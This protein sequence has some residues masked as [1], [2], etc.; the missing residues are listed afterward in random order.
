LIFLLS[1]IYDSFSSVCGRG[2]LGQLRDDAD[3][4]AVLVPEALVVASKLF[5]L[6]KVEKTGVNEWRK[7]KAELHGFPPPY[8][9]HDVRF[10]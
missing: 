6:L 10:E 2:H 1:S 9:W 5:N 8:K 7:T 3:Q 4:G